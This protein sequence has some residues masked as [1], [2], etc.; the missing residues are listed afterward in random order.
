VKA[1]SDGWAAPKGRYNFITAKPFQDNADVVFSE[2]MLARDAA[3]I[4]DQ[5]FG[6][7]TN[8]RSRGCLACFYSLWGYKAPEILDY[9]NRLT[10]PISAPADQLSPFRS[11]GI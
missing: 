8:R 7:R 5:L 1:L 9:S 4:S 10:G 6:W 3:D 2:M 11:D